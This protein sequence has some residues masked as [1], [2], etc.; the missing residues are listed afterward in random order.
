MRTRVITVEYQPGQTE[1]AT[2]IIREGIVPEG[3]KLPGWRGILLL[4]E[5]GGTHGLEISLW[6]SAEA[7][8]NPSE[9]YRAQ[10]V[11]FEEVL[12]G[13]A[14]REAYEVNV[15]AGPAFD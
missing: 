8:E 3:R 9:A 4:T 14:V 5:P 1:E 2:G 7:M 6:D 15:F 12:A 10:A 13:P 11:R